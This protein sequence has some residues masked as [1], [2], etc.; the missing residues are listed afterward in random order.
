MPETMMSQ[1]RLE[2]VLMPETT[3][4]TD[5]TIC[6]RPKRQLSPGVPSMA[7]A[8][9]SWGAVW[10]APKKAWAGTLRTLTGACRVNEEPTPLCSRSGAVMHTSPTWLRALAAS[11]NPGA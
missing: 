4:S 2:P 6:S 3:R 10:S 9:I 7:W 5:L 11:H 1:P 8:V